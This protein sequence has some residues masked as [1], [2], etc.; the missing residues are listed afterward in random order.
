VAVTA[1]N[2]LNGGNAV[3]GTS[4][5]DTN[6]TNGTTYYYVV[7]AVGGASGESPAS[8]QVSATPTAPQAST[9]RYNSGG[10]AYLDSQGQQWSADNFFQNGSTY[11]TPSTADILNTTDDTLYRTER[12]GGAQ[13][14][15]ALKYSIPVMN[16]TY[17]VRLHFAEI[18]HGVGSNGG[19][20]GS[21]VF[22]VSIEG[23]QVL[24]D[25]DI[26]QKAGGALKAVVEPF[27]ANVSD[28][29]LDI[30]FAA[31]VD[32]AKVSAI[33]VIPGNVPTP[34]PSSTP[35]PTPTPSPSAA[36]VEQ[37]GQVV[38]EAE[39]YT[40]LISRGGKSWSLTN[41]P[42][43]FVGQGAMFSGPNT[44]AQ[45][46]TNYTTTTPEMQYRI[47]FSTPGTYHVWLRGQA[48]NQQDNAAHVGLNGQAIASADRMTVNPGNSW[49]WSKSTM[50]G[51]VATINIPSAGVYT[52]NV[53][54]REDGLKIDR[55]LLTTN[56]TLVPSGAGPPES[57]FASNLRLGIE[58]DPLFSRMSVAMMNE[59]VERPDV[60][61]ALFESDLVKTMYAVAWDRNQ[62][63]FPATVT[64][65]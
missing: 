37:G 44:G 2:A 48:G 27:Q 18:W 29:F 4:Y 14:T 8:N 38:I 35:T 34:T 10:A 54:M 39:K 30:T 41:T 9:Q 33:E 53:W 21:R 22:N 55:L 58:A 40:Q 52:L 50:D 23:T 56:A 16:G 20:V 11:T 17:T 7:T 32:N 65:Q 36:F 60:L 57:V 46:D 31:S 28:G 49:Q 51:P 62:R 24:T 61:P 64:K 6:V 15:A 45:V 5:T 42:T 63:L 59:Q 26:Y 19:G 43:G 12:Y 1:A 3:F 25:Y 13:G 47:K